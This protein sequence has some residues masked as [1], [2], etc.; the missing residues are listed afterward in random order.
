MIGINTALIVQS[1]MAA[2]FIDDF[3]AR[4]QGL[5]R[6]DIK[7]IWDKMGLVHNMRV[8][9]IICILLNALELFSRVRIFNFFAKFVRQLIEI[10][11]DAMPLAAMLSVI[12][13]A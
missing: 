10:C 2:G 1:I 4:T 3:R 5:D 12:V 6:E 11:S 13:L 7:D 8:N 9:M